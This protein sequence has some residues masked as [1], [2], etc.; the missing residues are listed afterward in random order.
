MMIVFL[1]LL[2]LEFSLSGLDLMCLTQYN[3]T[4]VKKLDTQQVVVKAKQRGLHCGGGHSRDDC[5]AEVPQCG[6]CNGE[7]RANSRECP[8]VQHA[9]DIE[10][11][12]SAGLSYQDA[13]RVYG[14]LPIFFFILR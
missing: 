1:F 4:T 3:A 14:R 9:H 8:M 11:L 10:Q 5:V 13:L 6:G 7:H 2:V 12:R